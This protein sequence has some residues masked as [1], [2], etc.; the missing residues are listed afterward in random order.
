MI[1]YKF[2]KNSPFYLFRHEQYYG[3]VDIYGYVQWGGC[4]F[5]LEDI[6][7]DFRKFLDDNV[8]KYKISKE[9]KDEA[10]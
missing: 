10:C 2:P 7:G 5:H 6:T 3:C 9:V 1:K 4:G 8:S